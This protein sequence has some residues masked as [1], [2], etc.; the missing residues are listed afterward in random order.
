MKHERKRR[1]GFL[2]SCLLFSFLFFLWKFILVIWSFVFKD[3]NFLKEVYYHIILFIIILWG[4][5]FFKVESRVVNPKNRFF[6]GSND[7]SWNDRVTIG[8]RKISRTYFFLF[9][10]STWTPVYR[11]LKCVICRWTTPNWKKNCFNN[12]FQNKFRQIFR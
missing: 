9:D 2:D 8:T 10:R 11:L 3:S 4:E 6:F 5:L 1:M 12:F 7:S